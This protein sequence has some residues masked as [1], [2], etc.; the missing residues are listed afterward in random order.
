MVCRSKGKN[1]VTKAAYNGARTLVNETTNKKSSY[2]Q[3]K[4]QVAFSKIIAPPNS[5][6][7]V[8]DPQR[9]WNEVE[10]FEKRKDS[11]VARE[12]IIALPK[13]LSLKKQ[14]ELIEEYVQTYLVSKGMTADINLHNIGKNPH[15][16]HV[17]ILLPTRQILTNEKFGKKER[18]WNKK[19]S[20]QSWRIGWE[21]ICNRFLD[22]MQIKTKVTHR[23]YAA[24][25]ISLLPTLHVGN[26][27]DKEVNKQL[28]KQIKKI[29]FLIKRKEIAF[30][31]GRNIYD[32]IKQLNS[33]I[34]I[35]FEKK[36]LSNKIKKLKENLSN[37]EYIFN[38]ISQS[39]LNSSCFPTEPN[40]FSQ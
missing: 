25:N 37:I 19:S 23:S 21:E 30:F 40:L 28:N 8:Y 36:P 27:R 39:K 20:L 31:K 6:N 13:E 29:N 32:E 35:L 4:T 12:L 10:K 11:Q 3:K 26:N 14:I 17:H 16:P 2:P 22:K 33:I 9:L 5:P 15:N 1:A 24:R 34:N 18:E 38:K 7:W